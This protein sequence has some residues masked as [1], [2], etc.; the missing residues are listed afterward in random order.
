MPQPFPEPS[1]A[2][3]VALFRLGVVGDLLARDVT[4]VDLRNPP[5]PTLRL[6]APAAAPI[7]PIQTISAE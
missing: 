5:R 4:H 6:A 7:D 2:E 1:R 3:A